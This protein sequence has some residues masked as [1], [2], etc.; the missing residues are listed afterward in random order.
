MTT[1]VRPHESI[2]LDELH[3]LIAINRLRV[4]HYRERGLN[5]EADKISNHIDQM[6]DE[7]NE[8]R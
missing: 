2:G 5:A 4:K 1:A 8:R 7:I 3:T 6:L